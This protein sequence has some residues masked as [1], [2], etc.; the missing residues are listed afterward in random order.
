MK[1][2]IVG[3]GYV[4]LSLAALLAQ[5]HEVWVVDINST[6]V[7]LIN[8]KQSP[9]QDDDISN[10]L[11]GEKVRLRA[12]TDSNQAFEES[13]LVIIATPTDYKTETNSFDTSSVEGVCEAVL[14]VNSQ[15]YIVIK[16]TVPVG[17][18]SELL[19]RMGT[20]RILFSPEFLR[21]GR[22]LQDNLNP[23]RIVV[24]GH[25]TYAEPFSQLLFE[26]AQ[27]NPEVLLT[28]T[29]EAEA[30]KLFSNTYLAMRVAFFN[31]LDTYC[32]M[33]EIHSKQVIKGVCLDERIGS[34]Y[35]NPSFGYGGY[36]LPKDTKQLLATYQKV[37]QNLIEAIVK[38]NVTRKDFIANQII[39]SGA[40]IVGVY[41]LVMKSGSDNFRSSAIQGVIERM[42][43]K[44]V[45][46]IIYEPVIN[47]DK[48]MGHKLV[49]SLNDFKMQS[50]L[51]IANR[52]TDEISDVL[53]KVYTRD[54]FEAD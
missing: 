8:R 38:A 23:S 6:K 53:D 45:Q 26:V 20:N 32:E 16:S 27:N 51:I 42:S 31:E 44:G 4:G 35:N 28:T 33:R 46:I 7:D 39:K 13:S 52:V 3:A 48:F 5:K 30:I 1:I 10:Y 17:F 25:I 29:D 40:R 19:R 24:G 22:S 36:C 43:G 15:A 47:E 41:R 50:E 54:L 37:P 12:T 14:R 11:H 49:K 9:I 21:E 18:T 2:A 34:Y